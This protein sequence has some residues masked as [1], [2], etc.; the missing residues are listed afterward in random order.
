MVGREKDLVTSCL[1]DMK[2]AMALSPAKFPDHDAR[3]VCNVVTL[4]V[5]VLGALAYSRLPSDATLDGVW[6]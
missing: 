6:Q 5:V 1:R 3:G 4:V 2:R